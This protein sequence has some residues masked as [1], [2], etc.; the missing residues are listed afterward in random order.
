KPFANTS[1]YI[2]DVYGE[3][4][5]IG[6]AGELY[7]GG[8]GV[9]RGYLNRPE[10]TGERFLPDGIGGGQR[11]YRA[12]DMA[13]WLGNGEIEFIGR[14]DWQVKVRGFR[15]ELGEI[16]AKLGQVQGVREVVVVAR[17]EG[18]GKQ[19]LVA[20][21]TGEE[22][23]EAHG[24]WLEA[25]Q[26]L[27]EYM[28]PGAYVYLEKLPLTPN[29]KVDRKALPEP[30]GEAYAQQV[31]EAPEG[32]IER[33]LAGIWAELLKVERVGRHDNFFALGGHSLLAIHLKERLN[34]AGL[35]SDVRMIFANPTLAEFAAQVDEFT[36]EVEVP[37][38]LLLPEFMEAAMAEINTDI[39][40]FRL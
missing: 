40:E 3:P 38:N 26:R 2:L 10:L 14:N 13:R 15:I 7:I 25:S 28:V 23:L 39:E 22:A 37:P 33:I 4:V 32:E 20:Y 31:Y 34:R 16:E 35:R 17:E 6:V 30:E 9:G 12:G 5:P 11:M 36:E 24:L 8:A 29:G 21:Y 1:M 27:P 19:R 18:P